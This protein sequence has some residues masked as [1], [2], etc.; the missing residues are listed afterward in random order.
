MFK[1]TMTNL[2]LVCLTAIVA[3]GAV[4][5][6]ATAQTTIAEREY[7]SGKTVPKTRDETINENS[8]TDELRRGKK[9]LDAKTLP[10]D[11]YDP[12]AVDPE[13]LPGNISDGTKPD[14]KKL[15][16]DMYQKPAPQQ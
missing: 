15:P 5:Q 11:M 8:L 4:A 16:G 13:P 9:P 12:R 1:F 10:G 6:K 3:E 7:S 14:S 2:G